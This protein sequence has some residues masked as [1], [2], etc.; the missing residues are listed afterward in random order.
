M[1][2]V[3]EV[4]QRF[5]VLPN[6]FRLT[7]E[8]PDITAKLWG[9]A[10][11]GYLDNPLPSLFKE[12]LFVWLS[13]FCEVRYCIVRHVGFLVGLGRVAGDACCIPQSVEE[14]LRLV[15]RPVPLAGSLQTCIERC[16]SLKEP[17]SVMPQPDSE[18][19]WA[20]FA[21]ATHMFLRTSAESACSDALRRAL[22]PA[23]TENF[24]LL[25][26]FIRTAHFWTE[27]HPELKFEEDIQHLLV[28]HRELGQCLLDDPASEL[29]NTSQSLLAELD[30]L[31]KEK[32][33]IERESRRR[34]ENDLAESRL[35]H[36]LSNELIGEQQVDVLYDKII[37]AAAR[38]MHSPCATMHILRGRVDGSKA[39]ELLG[40][41]GFAKDAAK[42]WEQV[43]LESATMCGSALSNG[44]RIV[45][46][47]TEQCSTMAGSDEL[48]VCRKLGIRAAQTTPLYSRAGAMVGT[49]STYWYDAREP[50]EHEFHAF[51]ILA[52]QAADLIERAQANEALRASEKRLMTII[53]QLPAGVGVMDATG[54]WTLNNTLMKQYMPTS[55]PSRRPD[56]DSHWRVWDKD[57]NLSAPESWP[58][59]R[60]LGGETV[61]PGMEMLYTDDEGR[62][63]WMRVSAAPL[64]NDSGDIIGAC[65]IVQDTT[66]LKRAEHA[67]R[68]A[69][70]R[71]DEFIATLAHELRNPMAPIR[72]GLQI[73]RLS[74]ADNK[75]AEQIHGMLERQVNQMVRLI[76]DLLEV[77]RIASGKIELRREPVDLATVLHS[78]VETSR[79]LIDA[80]G[81]QLTISLPH[82]SLVLHADP[83]RIAQVIA[84][85]LNNAAKYTDPGGQILLTARRDRAEA[86][87]TVR[88][89]GMGI[90]QAMLGRIF[91]L[92]TQAER[93]YNRAQG[94]LGVG[95]TLVRTLVEM[96][97]GSVEARSEGVGKGSEFQ[98]RLPVSIQNRQ[99]RELDQQPRPSDAL[100]GHR[101]LVVDDNHDAAD[102]LGMLLKLYGADVCVVR[103]GPAA[104]AALDT[105]RADVVLLDIGMPGMDGYEVARRVREKPDFHDVTLIALTGWGQEEDR[106][107]SKD[108][109]IDHHLVKPVNVSAL[110]RLLA[111][112]RKRGGSR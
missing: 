39:L 14:I 24:L 52:R 16:S 26:A 30:S 79:A 44:H 62:E 45:V 6:F 97:G 99:P 85:L 70:R 9:F 36:E 49:I 8:N 27:L 102:S 3:D 31:R 101:I 15:R 90:P 105:Y 108:A 104:L 107:Q 4:R 53:E 88:D 48:A 25:L 55:I 96:H 57:G 50:S 67:L 17:L 5:G 83:V 32:L 41:R 59:I 12:R 109:G 38:L 33:E 61:M 28:T 60:A 86:I 72:N 100:C 81:H 29:G 71:K 87:V 19:E 80:A 112:T 51:D 42:Q 56:R 22:G 75:A 93:S 64:Q 7:P 20:M 84:N 74:G 103:D 10:C 111:D 54:V 58:C 68:E 66:Q 47:D 35:L 63:Y 13:R 2:L 106:R 73:L 43:D 69:D 91:D 82:E 37:D 11:F 34:L 46:P 89:N 78:A 95:L 40:Y 1:S 18:L 92:F 21:C 94:G 23:Q 65:C 76:D 110:E 98:V 77:S